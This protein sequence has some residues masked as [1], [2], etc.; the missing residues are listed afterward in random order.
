MHPDGTCRY[1]YV[2]PAI[3][4]I[5]GLTPDQALNDPMTVVG[6]MHPDDASQVRHHYG[7]LAA[8]QTP[9][10]YQYRVHHPKQ[11]LLWVEE[12]AQPESLPDGSVLWHGQIVDITEF[13]VM[14]S[15]LS[16]SRARL[17]EASELAQLGH[18]EMDL[19]T[20]GVWWCETT[21][22]MLGC[23]LCDF[24]LT[25]EEH[26]GRVHPDD[27]DRVKANHEAALCARQPNIK[28][29][30]CR[31][32]RDNGEFIWATHWARIRFD[33]LGEPVQIFGTTQD[34]SERK[35]LEQTL[36]ESKMAADRA[37]QFKSDFVLGMSHELRTPLNAVL[38]FGQL[39][40]HD[41]DLTP[42]QAANL[43]EIQKAGQHLVGLI[44]EILDLSRVESGRLELSTSTEDCG[45]LAEESLSLVTA[46]AEERRVRLEL[47]VGDGIAVDCDP[48]RLRQVIVNL[49]SNGIKYNRPNGEVKLSVRRQ[50]DGE[51]ESV[52]I[53]IKDT[54]IGIPQDRLDDVFRPFE[55]LGRE[56]VEGTGIGL[57]ISKKLV[58]AMGGTL[59]VESR[60]GSGS[61]FSIIMPLGNGAHPPVSVMPSVTMKAKKARGLVLHI[62]DSTTNLRLLQRVLSRSNGVDYMGSPTG[63]LGLDLAIAYKPRLI[64]LDLE[65]P[66]MHGFE[67][68]ERLRSMAATCHI[69]VVGLTARASAKDISKGLEAGFDRYIGMPFDIDEVMSAIQAYMA[70][71]ERSLS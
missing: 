56:H 53:D 52:R 62:D 13:K 64:F 28:P 45:M 15:E 7:H 46:L 36:I 61:R 11:G 22:N 42:E 65:L 39:L 55:R 37:N 38:G 24:E 26:W 44:D 17:R 5:F 23:N 30:E 51:Q 3:E 69:P 47:D 59:T 12:Y 8:S 16:L 43:E 66:D 2:N 4:A 63:S 33:E 19:R 34:V 70:D 58:E 6:R 27:L 9:L 10:R 40:Q 57:V 18:W 20:N 48:I 71:D 35:R 31:I 29:I 68:L 54:G 49:L 32:R 67:V 1:E 60:Q 14:G 50:G 41:P 21:C 25:A